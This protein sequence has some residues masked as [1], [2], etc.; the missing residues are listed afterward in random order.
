MTYAIS[1]AGVG[2]CGD[3]RQTHATAWSRGDYGAYY[4][5]CANNDLG[6]AMTHSSTTS[7]CSSSAAVQMRW[8]P[9]WPVA[10]KLQSPAMRRRASAC[11]ATQ[12]GHLIHTRTHHPAPPLAHTITRLRSPADRRR[13]CTWAARETCGS[14]PPS[15]CTRSP[16]SLALRIRAS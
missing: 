6:S 3:K 4:L 1:I 11:H 7:C 13:T 14:L 2:A 10:L 15:H 5:S 16:R 8:S 9:C 12:H